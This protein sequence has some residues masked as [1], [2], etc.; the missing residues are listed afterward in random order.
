MGGL[1]VYPPLIYEY[2]GCTY[3][4][5]RDVLGR[6]HLL[7]RV[8][9]GSPAP[10]YIREKHTYKLPAH[11]YLRGEYMYIN[12]AYTYVGEKCLVPVAVYVPFSLMYVH[13]SLIYIYVGFVYVYSPLKYVCAGVL[14]V[15]TPLIYVCRVDI[16]YSTD[17]DGSTSG[18]SWGFTR[19][20]YLKIRMRAFLMRIFLRNMYGTLFAAMLSAAIRK[21]S[22]YW[23][24]TGPN[25][26]NHRDDFRRPALP[27]G[28]LKPLSREHLHSRARHGSPPPEP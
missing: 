21:I 22:L 23:Q 13:F 9:C 28:S 7:S 18:H 4:L 14:Y 5:R 25:S 11:T 2:I 27:S 26:L 17:G 8:R 3:A 6:N 20:C 24:P 15:Y 19:I 16:R 12:P 1:Y 10:P